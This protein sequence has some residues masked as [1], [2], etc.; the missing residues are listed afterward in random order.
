M[1]TQQI[2][3]ILVEIKASVATINTCWTFFQAPYL[4][5][6]A[7][8]FKFPVPSEYDFELLNNVL[9]WRL[10]D[11]DFY[12]EV[13]AGNYE[14][15][16]S[17]RSDAII[18]KDTL[19]TPGTSITMAMVVLGI[20][21]SHEDCPLQ[22]GSSRTIVVPSGGRKWYAPRLSR[23]WF[24][25]IVA[26]STQCGVWFDAA[27]KPREPLVDARMQLAMDEA[28]KSNQGGV[29]KTRRTY[30]ATKSPHDQ[31]YKHVRSYH[32]GM[33]SAHEDT[34]LSHSLG[35][36]HRIK[37]AY[38]DRP[39]THHE[40]L[41][42]MRDFGVGAIDAPGVVHQM[43]ALIIGQPD[44]IEGFDTFL[45]PGYTVRV[46]NDGSGRSLRCTTPETVSYICCE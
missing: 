35:F 28:I 30:R 2:Y 18:T 3:E 42:I 25:L 17:N 8:G 4:V 43:S 16:K 7:L 9:K 21:S 13:E 10:R 24:L 11:R 39:E 46:V 34:S 20:M 22:C 31:E 38:S 23:I 6:D 44:L 33:S 5:E 45:P 36:M 41:D 15:S 1:S 32:W 12:P 40:L 19:L 26:P 37:E 27:T 14:L 29:V